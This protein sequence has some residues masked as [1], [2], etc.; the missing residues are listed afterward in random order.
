MA[1]CTAESVK[2]VFT[3]VFRRYGLPK[4]IRSDN[5]TPFA[6]NYGML[7]LTTLSAWWI[8]LGIIPDRIDP[9]TPTQ[10][11]SHERMHVD[12]SKEIQGKIAGGRAGN[13]A[14]IDMWVEEYNDIRPHE[15]LGMLTPAEVYY[16]SERKYDG[17]FDTIEYPAGYLP[18]KVSRHGLIKIDSVQVM[19]GNALRGFTVGLQPIDEKAFMVWLCD[20]PLGILSTVTYS[21]SGLGEA[22]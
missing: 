9:G 18:R 11:G 22:E 14:A 8:S 5:G 13:Q 10:N 4:V 16:P 2:A 20:F 7:G 12:I 3:E 21:F 1:S 17:D 15:A 6:A 19:L